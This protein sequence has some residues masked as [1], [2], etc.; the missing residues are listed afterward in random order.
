MK[1][2]GKEEKGKVEKVED[3]K[4]KAKEHRKAKGSREVIEHRG[5]HKRKKDKE[6][7]GFPEKMIDSMD[8]NV[9]KL[10]QEVTEKRKCNESDLG[11]KMVQLDK[12]VK[13]T[14]R[15][16]KEKKA[17]AERMA[18]ETMKA[19][20]VANSGQPSAA[21]DIIGKKATEIHKET[22]EIH[23]EVIEVAFMAQDKSKEDQKNLVHKE[24]VVCVQGQDMD[25]LQVLVDTDVKKEKSTVQDV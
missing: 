20:R 14:I 11:N 3:F 24:T 5:K 12:V 9:Q 2:A 17:V 19:R 25:N 6:I 16:Q 21:G 8:T 18:E 23:G 1:E 4:K 13:K 22:T 7:Q 15:L 10:E